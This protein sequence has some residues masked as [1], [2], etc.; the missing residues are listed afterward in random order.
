VTR[1]V[2]TLLRQYAKSRHISLAAAMN[3]LLG[4]AL[5]QALARKD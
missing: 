4:D 2:D 1:E 3:S 5:T